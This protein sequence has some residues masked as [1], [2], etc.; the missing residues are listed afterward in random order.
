LRVD[1]FFADAHSASNLN[2]GKG[3]QETPQYLLD[4][5]CHFVAISAYLVGWPC[6]TAQRHRSKLALASRERWFE[7]TF[8]EFSG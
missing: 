2:E 7:W 5:R 8:S 6:E 1:R 4:F 3:P